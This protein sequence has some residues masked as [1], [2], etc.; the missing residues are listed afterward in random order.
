MKFLVVLAVF[1]AF[2]AALPTPNEEN[3][4]TESQQSALLSAD[5][6]AQGDNSERSKRFIFFKKIFVG[7]PPISVTKYYSP[8]VAYVAP[9]PVPVVTPIVQRTKVVQVAAPVVQ[10]T[11]VAAPVV[12]APVIHKTVVAAPVVHKTVVAAPVAP[13]AY[14]YA[15]P[16]IHAQVHIPSV[17]VTKTVTAV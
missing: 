1:I 11:V 13:V 4:P 2:A 9:A 12:A 14:T 6:N 10:K 16:A 8:P 3:A 5:A 17:S 15:A 7:L